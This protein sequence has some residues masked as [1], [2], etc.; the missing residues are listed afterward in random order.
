[1]EGYSLGVCGPSGQ[2][3]T[4]LPLEPASAWVARRE[5]SSGSLK[6]PWLAWRNQ[7]SRPAL[8]AS[9]EMEEPSAH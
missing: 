2:G 5:L 8:R 6:L 3:S 9:E 4:L 1:M 7:G